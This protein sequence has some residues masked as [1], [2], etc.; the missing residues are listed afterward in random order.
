MRLLEYFIDFII[1]SVV[2]VGCQ[3]CELLNMNFE[4]GSKDQYKQEPRI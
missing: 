4:R 2:K 3:S 1:R